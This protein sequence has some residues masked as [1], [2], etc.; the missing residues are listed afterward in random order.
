[1]LTIERCKD[2]I[3]Y[4]ADGVLHRDDG[5]AIEHRSGIV[6]WYSHGVRHRADGP[7]MI[8]PAIDILSANTPRVG[9]SRWFLNG[10]EYSEE[11]Y[12]LLMFMNCDIC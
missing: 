6:M 4:Y 1:M 7:A 5:P 12:N 10:V 8:F 2:R 3:S 9:F 11:D